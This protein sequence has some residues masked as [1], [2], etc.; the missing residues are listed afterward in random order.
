MK[1]FLRITAIT[2]IALILAIPI[3]FQVFKKKIRQHAQKEIDLYIN[4][5]VHFNDL[6]V[7]MIRNFPNLTLTLENVIVQGDSLF[8]K[9]T[10]ASIHE[11]DCELQTFELAFWR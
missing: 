10:L 3:S 1:R 2:V 9:D 4:G 11:F 7:S 6:T 5:H 8:K